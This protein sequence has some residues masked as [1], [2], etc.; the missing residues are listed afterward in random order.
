MKRFLLSLGLL[1]L[2]ALPAM[3]Q[4]IDDLPKVHARLVSEN[5]STSPG[6]SVTVALEEDI[7]PGW[8]TYWINPGDAGAPT[9]IKWDLP[10]GWSVDP[11]QW[12]TPKRLPVGPLMDYGYEGKLWLLQTLHIP[13]DAK[14]GDT[15]PLK[16]AVDWLVCKDICV[17]E[18]TTLTLPLKIGPAQ[19]DPAVAKDFAQARSLLPVPSPWKITFAFSKTL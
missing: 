8:H 9:E 1:G 6:G 2:L 3:A 14:P 17:P 5:L 11:I 18:D 19:P 4:G 13:A 15:V 7:R 10:K 12:P 16:A